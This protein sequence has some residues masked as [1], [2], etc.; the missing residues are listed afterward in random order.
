MNRNVKARLPLLFIFLVLLTGVGAMGYPLVSDWFSVYTAKVEIADYDAAVEEEDVSA[1]EE[2]LKEAEEY[3]KALSEGGGKT[4][5]A[6]Y[7][8]L[9]AVTDAIGYLEIPKLGV[10]MPI[11]HG[12]SDEVLQK[13]I[14]H[15]E[16]TSLPVGGASTHSVLSGHTGLPA[17]KILTDLDQMEEGDRFYIH[18]L[19][20]VLAYEVDQIKVVLPEETEDIQIVKGEDYVTLLTCTPYGIN[21][22]RLLVRGKRT[23][24]VPEKV[25][26]KPPAKTEPKKMLP[27]ETILLCTGIA[28]GAAIL[29]IIFL[30]LFAPGRKSKE[31]E[32]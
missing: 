1:L 17:A 28:A 9:L 20:R 4:S 31:R 22:H 3:N 23:E 25:S 19:N 16:D 13:G 10:Y 18:V 26:V 21:S 15:M 7:D 30:I 14:G 5:V 2:M 12:T 32:D 27:L 8:D 6:S 29:L 11:Y 24:Y